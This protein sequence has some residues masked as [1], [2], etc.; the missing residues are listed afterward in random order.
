MD[1]LNHDN[2]S[3]VIEAF[4]LRKTFSKFYRRHYEL[5]S[6]YNV[7]LKT[8][9]IEGLSE[10][11]FY[12]DLVYKCKKLIG[13]NDFSFQFRKITT[14][15][16]RIGYNLNVMRQSACLVFNPIMVDSYAAFFN[17]TPVGRASDSMMAPT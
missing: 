15:Y 17:C 11:E 4:K 9:L 5:I 12:G 6:K 16:R 7:G 8:L 10:P 13:I 3:D 1:S 14:H 2:Q